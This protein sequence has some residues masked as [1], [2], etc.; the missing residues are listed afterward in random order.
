MDD[1]DIII[2]FNCNCLIK[3]HYRGWFIALG[4]IDKF[5]ICDIIKF[6]LTKWCEMGLTNNPQ[7]LKILNVS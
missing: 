3:H 6:L 4:V 1:T 5:L 7:L 2:Y